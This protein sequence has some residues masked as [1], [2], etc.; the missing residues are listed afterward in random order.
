M[1][2]PRKTKDQRAALIAYE[3]ALRQEDRYLGSV[4]VTPMGQR[5][6][7]ARTAQAYARCKALGMTYEHGL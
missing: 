7:E 3:Y 6:V 2:K 1:A 4:F 5:E